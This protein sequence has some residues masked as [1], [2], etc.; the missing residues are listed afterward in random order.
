MTIQTGTTYQLEGRLLE[1]CTCGVLC[2]CWVGADPDGGTC[3]SALGWHIDRGTIQGVDVSGLTIA[4]SVHIPG[5][6]LKGN[7]RALVYVDEQATSA[8]QDALLAAFTGKLG[9][10]IADLASLIGEVVGVERVP[11]TFTV[12]GGKGTLLI[13][14]R[15]E[16][17]LVPLTG[18]SGEATTLH[19]SIFSTIPGSPAYVGRAL[20][21]RSQVPALGHDLNLQGHNAIQR[22]F[23]FV[24]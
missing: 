23:R 18:P 17:E 7:W 10:P 2:P 5:N 19:E 14:E 15:V 24:A 3:D 9:G 13:G 8:Q 12:E 1:V 16:A 4:L 6:V 20:S 11:I 22:T 21:Y